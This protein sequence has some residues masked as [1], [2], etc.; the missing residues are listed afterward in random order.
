MQTPLGRVRGLGPARAGTS[1][2]WWQRLTSVANVFLTVFLLFSVVRHIGE[3]YEAVIDY[4]GS[5]FVSIG[6]MLFV[7]SAIFHMYMGLKVIIEDYVQHEGWKI[8]SLMGNTFFCIATGFA[9]L[10]AILKLSF[11][12]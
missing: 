9:C 10:F 12:G 5:P 7:I 3:P 8:L 4:L 1:H 2:F 6:L 11:G